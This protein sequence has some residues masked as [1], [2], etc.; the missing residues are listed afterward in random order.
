[1]AGGLP[2]DDQPRTRE[3]A[4]SWAPVEAVVDELAHGDSP[5]PTLSDSTLPRRVPHHGEEQLVQA[6]V[7][8]QFGWNAVQDAAFRT[9]MMHARWWPRR[10]SCQAFVNTEPG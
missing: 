6:S 8:G 4:R 1:M 5:T 3:H 2:Q 9:A 7:A 10:P